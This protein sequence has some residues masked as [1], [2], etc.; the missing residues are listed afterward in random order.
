MIK[1]LAAHRDGRDNS[2]AATE[3]FTK[4]QA[5]IDAKSA[6]AI[7]YLD[8]AKIVKLAIKANAEEAMPQAQQTDVLAKELGV[9]GLKSAGGSFSLGSGN[10]DS[11]TKTFFN[12]PRPADRA[13]Q[14]LFVA[15]GRAA[16]RVV[17]PRHGGHLPD[18]QFRSGQC[19]HRPRRPGQQVPA[20]HDQPAR[21][22]AGRSQRRPAPELSRTI[23]SGRSA[24]GSR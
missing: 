22:A 17:G 9:F 21:A 19:L 7:W 20:R 4:T 13:S 15:A 5:K 24:T 3:S 14:G 11:L 23:S 2:L 16:A 18:R 10:Y 8:I 6:Q 1:D 12:A